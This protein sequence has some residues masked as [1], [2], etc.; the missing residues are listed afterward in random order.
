VAHPTTRMIPNR[1]SE[2]GT[3]RWGFISQRPAMHRNFEIK[4]QQNRCTQHPGTVRATQL[5]AINKH[6]AVQC[7]CTLMT[8]LIDKGSHRPGRG[9]HKLKSRE[10][11]MDAPRS[12]ASAERALESEMA[13]EI[14]TLLEQTVLKYFPADQPRVSS[15][16]LVP[17]R[18]EKPP[19]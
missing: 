8:R 3:E 18:Q 10:K 9:R 13:E 4:P 6:R 17:P 14:C 11:L 2:L 7:Y 16:P 19:T 15:V 5:T 1:I 12:T